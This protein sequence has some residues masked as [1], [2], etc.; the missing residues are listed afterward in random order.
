MIARYRD[1]ILGAVVVASLVAV[2]AIFPLERKLNLGL[3][4]QGGMHLVMEVDASKIPQGT[5][6]QDAVD[7]AIEIIRNRVDALGVSEPVIQRQGESWIVVQL[8]GVKDPQKAIDLIGETALLEFKLVSEK[9]LD[10]FLDKA[11]NVDPKKLP[12]DLEVVPGRSPN[13]RYLIEK[14]QLM[15]GN[16]LA[17]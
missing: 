2:W 9:N 5:T 14:E 11:G 4:L 12:K 6:V 8:P 15:T 1:A 13:D 17:D 10:E 7:R 16:S 3:D